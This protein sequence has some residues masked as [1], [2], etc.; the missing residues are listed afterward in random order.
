RAMARARP[1]VSHPTPDIPTG[2]LAL[3][4]QARGAVT[5]ALELYSRQGG[6]FSPEETAVLQSL[7]GQ[8]AVAIDNASLFAQVQENYLR[9]NQLYQAGQQINAATRPAGVFQ[10]LV[11]YA[12]AGRQV[13]VA[14]VLS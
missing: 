3:P 7:A 11:N 8:V 12:A 5:G 13:D 14:F 6:S 10:A 4:L 2:C 1:A 9:V